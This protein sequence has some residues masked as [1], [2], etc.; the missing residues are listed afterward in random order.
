M[1]MGSLFDGLAASVEAA[2]IM[3]TGVLQQMDDALF[4]PERTVL[5]AQAVVGVSG[6]GDLPIPHTKPHRLPR[7]KQRG[8]ERMR[9]K[10]RKR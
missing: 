2:N 1:Q 6:Y 10:K 5:I 4:T 9:P 7:N 3:C 8:L